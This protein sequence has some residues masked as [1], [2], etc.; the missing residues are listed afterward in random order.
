MELTDLFEYFLIA[1]LP[2]QII[3]LIFYAGFQWHGSNKAR[4]VGILVPPLAVLLFWLAL[5]VSFLIAL[6]GFGALF[7]ISPLEWFDLDMGFVNIGLIGAILSMLLN[8]ACAFLIQS[9]IGL[10]VSWKERSLTTLN[11][12]N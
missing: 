9:G 12:D 5:I 1:I 3:G 6:G 4:L 10:G 11:L 7:S 8:L 2:F